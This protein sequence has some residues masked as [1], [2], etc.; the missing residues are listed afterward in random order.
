MQEHCPASH[1]GDGGNEMNT[2][3]QFECDPSKMTEQIDVLVLDDD[4][5]ALRLV[6]D[7]L[8]S[9][10]PQ[11][12]VE[13]RQTPDARGE[14]D[15]F[16]IDHDYHGARL[17]PT[18]ARQIRARHP[19]ALI[20][21]FSATLEAAS[22]KELINAG[23]NGACDKTVGNDLQRALE[24]TRAYVSSLSANGGTAG[25]GGFKGALESIRSLLGEWN[26]RLERAQI[27]IAQ[28]GSQQ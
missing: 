22:L 27:E 5:W 20:I 1:A 23:C 15:V 2:A 8:E 4:V 24:I 28:E 26:H 11:A 9:N 19:Q 18:L 7:L 14:F 21:A 12:R 25:S 13:T 3:K 16:F 17:A 6:K 10:F